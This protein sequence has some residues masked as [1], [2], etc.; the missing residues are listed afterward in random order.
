MS[1]PEINSQLLTA[2]A[3]GDLA[4]VNLLLS[5][6]ADVN[7]TGGDG[8]SALHYATAAG[9]VEVVKTLIEAGTN[10]NAQP[11]KNGLTPLHFA[12]HSARVLDAAITLLNAGADVTLTDAGGRTPFDMANGRAVREYYES[13]L[14]AKAISEAF[15]SGPVD[16]E[17]ITSKRVLSM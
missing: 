11:K 3:Q 17:A 4:L 9:C 16:D 12:A 1:L 5:Q 10:L 2:C 7:S 13:W 15:A 14:A 8:F 6:G